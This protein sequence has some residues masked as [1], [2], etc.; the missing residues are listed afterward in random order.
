MRNLIICPAGVPLTFDDRFNANEHWRLANSAPRYYETMVLQY[1]DYD[2]ESNSY[3]YHARVSGDKWQLAKTVLNNLDYNDY[4]YIGFFDDDLI[5]DIENVNRAIEIAQ[6]NSLKIF[7]MSV[8]TDSDIFWPILVNR[9]DIKYTVTN[10][11]E[12]MAPFIHRDL[13]SLCLELWNQYDIKSGWGFD[14]VI[15]DLTKVD[16]A[17][18]HASQM[19]H[20][21]RATSYNKPSAFEEMDH[22]LYNLF[23]KFVKTKYNE[24]WKFQ[25]LQY[26]KSIINL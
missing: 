20:P 22:L 9:P 21:K 16:A 1:K 3:D 6:S 2:I 12:V 18:I 10:F 26:E 11:V 4:E 25:E 23:P 17:V 14:K 19:Y 7:Q 5:T 24:D 13:I 15:C 8:T